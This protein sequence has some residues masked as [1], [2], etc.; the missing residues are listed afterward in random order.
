VLYAHAPASALEQVVALRLH[1]DD[2]TARNGPLRIL[3]GTHK[4][5]IVT[6]KAIE[7]LASSRTPVSLTA[8]VGDVIA[9]RPLVVH[10]SQKAQMNT[11]RRVLQIE[12][13]STRYFHGLELAL[14]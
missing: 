12:Y 3:P 6:D 8:K 11:R 7:Q 2:S 13:S 10:S 14:T 4:L 1:L 5:G 9:M